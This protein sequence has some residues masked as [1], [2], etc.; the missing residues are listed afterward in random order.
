[1][2]WRQRNSGPVP[3][4]RRPH[5]LCTPRYFARS[6]LSGKTPDLRKPNAASSPQRRRFFPSLPRNAPRSPRRGVSRLGSLT[7]TKQ[8]S[9][10]RAKR[11]VQGVTLSSPN[12]QWMIVVEAAERHMASRPFQRHDERDNSIDPLAAFLLRRFPLPPLRYFGEHFV[13]VKSGKPGRRRL[14]STVPHILANLAS[15]AC[16]FSSVR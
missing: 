11:R 13:K 16:E 5:R 15:K 10:T 1:M 4:A 9:A 12:F 8:K 7:P 3:A 14:F 6:T 2:R